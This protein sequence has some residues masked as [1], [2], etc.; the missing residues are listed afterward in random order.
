M[1]LYLQ[2]RRRE[3]AV[4]GGNRSGGARLALQETQEVRNT[5]VKGRAPCVYETWCL[6]DKLLVYRAQSI[7]Y[8]AACR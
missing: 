8:Y 1:G 7:L 2:Y 6:V 5:H 4:N 3:E